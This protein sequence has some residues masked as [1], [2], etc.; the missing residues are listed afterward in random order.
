MKGAVLVTG[1]AKRIGLAICDA[2]RARG[3]TVLVHSRDPANPLCA[4]LAEPGG[5]DRLFDRA[6]AAAP[7]LCAVVGNASEFSLA[8]DPPP[9]VADR[10][11][12]VNAAAPVRLAELLHA[13]LRA[14]GRAGAV[15][16]LLDTRVLGASAASLR[17]PYARA[18]AAL[19][20][21]TLDQA[22]ALAPVLRVNAVAPGPVLLPANPACAEPG[23]AILLARRPSPA[24]V[25]ASVAFLLESEF[26]TGQILAVDAGQSL[27][28]APRGR[29]GR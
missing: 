15:V 6:V 16:N 27:L 8:A 18:K 23:G 9:A 24:D 7:D 19:R 12:R 10:L 3:W 11:M 21:A 28:S 26:L 20:D 17:T 2:L 4:D 14:Q 22:R 5:A 29:S 25:A 1:G 13:R